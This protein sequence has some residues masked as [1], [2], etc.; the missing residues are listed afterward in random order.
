MILK[1]KTYDILALIQ[2]FLA[3]LST[4]VIAIMGIWGAPYAEQ[5]A[6]TISAVSVLLAAWL[7]ICSNKYF[8]TGTITFVNAL[9]EEEVDK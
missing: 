2:R 5:I 7:K 8:D 9:K 3:P 1:D 6:A 4:C